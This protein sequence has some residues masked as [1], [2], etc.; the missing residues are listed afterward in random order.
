MVLRNRKVLLDPARTQSRR[1]RHGFQAGFGRRVCDALAQNRKKIG[2][3]EKGRKKLEKV[4][5]QID[6]EI[7]MD[8]D[9]KGASSDTDADIEALLLPSTPMKGEC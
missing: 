1:N 3:I 6:S 8:E 4:R 7:M 5:F 2:K 9:F